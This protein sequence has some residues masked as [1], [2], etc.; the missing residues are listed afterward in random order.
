MLKYV[1]WDNTTTRGDTNCQGLSL[2]SYWGKIMNV[3]LLKNGQQRFWL[4]HHDRCCTLTQMYNF[5]AET[6]LGAG[7]MSAF[8]FLLTSTAW[9]FTLTFSGNTTLRKGPRRFW[10]HCH[11]CC[12]ILTLRC[13][14][15]PW[16]QGCEHSCNNFVFLLAAIAGL[17]QTAWSS[18]VMC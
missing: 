11:E 6:H 8:V 18:R 16:G 7:V 5:G 2:H 1:P 17:T 15:W 4:Y 12:G 13:Q 14:N 10:L 3:W 9:A